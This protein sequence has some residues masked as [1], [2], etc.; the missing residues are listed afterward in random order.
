[1]GRSKK[2]T[3]TSKDIYELNAIYENEWVEFIRDANKKG[4]S[5]E[6]ISENPMVLLHLFY[7]WLEHSYKFM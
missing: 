3:I 7:L 1:M 6:Q 5:D 2:T 4:F